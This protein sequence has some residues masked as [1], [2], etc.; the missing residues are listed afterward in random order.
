[1]STQLVYL[2]KKEKQKKTFTCVLVSSHQRGGRKMDWE[3]FY[4]KT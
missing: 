4:H 1:M 3:Y 2:G